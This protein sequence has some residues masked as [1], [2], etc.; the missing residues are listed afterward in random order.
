MKFQKLLIVTVLSASLGTAAFSQTRAGE[1]ISRQVVSLKNMMES[2]ANDIRP[3]ITTLETEMNAAEAQINAL[4]AQ[5]NRRTA[6]NDRTNTS[7]YWPDHPDANGNGCVSH[8][9]LG[10]GQTTTTTNQGCGVQTITWTGNGATCMA[11]TP[12]TPDSIE[13]IINDPDTGCR[14][15]YLGSARVRCSNGSYSFVGTGRTCRR[16]WNSCR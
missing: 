8:N 2:F 4:T 16:T 1:G 13:I 9:D 6:C 5:E 7:I 15:Q 3:R 10:T 11:S 12:P 14:D